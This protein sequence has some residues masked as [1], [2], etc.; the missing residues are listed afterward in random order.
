MW[1]KKRER[2]KEKKK[3]RKQE[4]L[5]AKQTESTELTTE[6]TTESTTEPA[7]KKPFRDTKKWKG[8][9]AEEINFYFPN[10][11]IDLSFTQGIP[12]Q[13]FLIQK[14]RLT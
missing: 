10:I 2:D 14:F 6:A 1:K 5:E 9:N 3:K 12:I 8:K 13:V 11:V 4:K 7:T